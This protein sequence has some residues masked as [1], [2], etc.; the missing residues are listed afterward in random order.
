MSNFFKRWSDLKQSQ[1]KS[2]PI[3]TPTEEQ[4][5]VK[6]TLSPEVLDQQLVKDLEEKSITESVGPT[7]DDVEKLNKDSDFSS[8]VNADVGE[9]VHHAAM[10][11]LFSDPHYN[12][13]DGLD[14][15]IDD[16]S[17]EDPLPAGMLEKM[18]QSSMLGLF[19][20]VEEKLPDLVLSENQPN[21]DV[22]KQALKVTH[23]EMEDVSQEHQENQTMMTKG[24]TDDSDTRL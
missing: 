8:F 13:M 4:T 5:E 2:L 22:N 18:V 12:I 6:E 14:I 24:S 20:K 15:Y 21:L 17:K 1:T 23:V 7:L 9:D 19:N 16:Y 10:K 11:K 3:E